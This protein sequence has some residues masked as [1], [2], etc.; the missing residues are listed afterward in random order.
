M[1]SFTFIK[2]LT[3]GKFLGQQ[4]SPLTEMHTK[5]EE[6]VTSHHCDE[7]STTDKTILLCVSFQNPINY[8]SL[9]DQQSFSIFNE[10]H[11]A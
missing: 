7:F 6:E 8:T 9:V 2:I 3:S 5:A 10:H 1:T 11:L 4:Q